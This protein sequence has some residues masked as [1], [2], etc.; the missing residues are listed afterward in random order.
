VRNLP[1]N[2]VE[3]VLQG[4]EENVKK[5]IELCREGP[6]FAE[7]KDVAVEWEN[8]EEQYDEFLII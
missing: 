8:V 6:P 2:R 7:V 4:K 3:A 5:M 1:D